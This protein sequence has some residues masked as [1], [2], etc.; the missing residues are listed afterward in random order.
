MP[1]PTPKTDEQKTDKAL[2]DTF[3][4]SDAPSTTPPAG[5]RKAEQAP[6]PRE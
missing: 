3:P 4:A 1:D 2:E 6:E 5:S